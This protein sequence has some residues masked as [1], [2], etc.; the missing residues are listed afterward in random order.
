MINDKKKTPKPKSK[1]IRTNSALI[2]WMRLPLTVRRVP[3]RPRGPSLKYH[4]G[5]QETPCQYLQPGE[6]VLP[7]SHFWGRGRLTR[8]WQI[9]LRPLC[10]RL[11]S[12]SP[13]LGP[14][15]FLLPAGG[16][17]WSEQNRTEQNGSHAPFPPR[18]EAQGAIS[19]MFYKA[20][21]LFELPGHPHCL[22]RSPQ[23][24]AQQMCHG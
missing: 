18:L 17:G 12:Q 23:A 1:T 21:L 14:P 6:K 24:L 4:N 20:D 11:C 10:L 13:S 2:V 7:W 8:P 9:G 15:L 5:F 19:A 16:Q 22:L 3:R